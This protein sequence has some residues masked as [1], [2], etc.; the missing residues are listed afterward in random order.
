MGS[1]PQS[2]ERADSTVALVFI[3]SLATAL[4]L[5]I[6]LYYFAGEF[7]EGLSKAE[8]AMLYLIYFY[9]VITAFAVAWRDD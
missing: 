1:R 4:L 3:A 6:A 9:T 7:R 2:K 8:F 5:P